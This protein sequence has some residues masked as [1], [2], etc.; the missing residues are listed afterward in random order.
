MNKKG[1]TLALTV[2]IVAV[3]II[4]SYSIFASLKFSARVKD[5]NDVGKENLEIADMTSNDVLAICNITANY[6][7][8]E[9]I[10]KGESGGALTPDA[11][12]K[13]YTD[14]VLSH[15][16]DNSQYTK[17][18]VYYLVNETSVVDEGSLSI[19]LSEVTGVDPSNYFYLFS[20]VTFSRKNIVS[21][22]RSNIKVKKNIFVNPIGLSSDE[23]EAYKVEVVATRDSWEEY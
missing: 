13:L 21:R 8:E 14:T 16:I 1:S 10:K 18:N 12:N 23:L 2:V 17:S 6:I 22:I 3:I 20:E 5:R 11:A 19:S 9:I 7:L 4:V 15:I